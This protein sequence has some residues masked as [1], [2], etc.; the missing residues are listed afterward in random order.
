MS[1][2]QSA[3]SPLIIRYLS[4]IVLSPHHLLT[5]SL[6]HPFILTLSQSSFP[7]SPQSLA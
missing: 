7:P 3:N 6:P 5:R 2:E 1:R 4:F